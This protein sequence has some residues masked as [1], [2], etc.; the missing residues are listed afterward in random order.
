MESSYGR[1]LLTYFG[2]PL[3]VNEVWDLD[4]ISGFEIS[5]RRR[6]LK[7]R[8]NLSDVQIKGKTARLFS[9]PVANEIVGTI[10][11]Q[12]LLKPEDVESLKQQD[13]YFRSDK[14]SKTK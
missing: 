10:E 2:T 14:V 3:V 11:R 5:Q 8:N 1:S 6:T 4:V 12:Q 7:L 9:R 13:S